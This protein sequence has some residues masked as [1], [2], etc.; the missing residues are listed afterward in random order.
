MAKAPKKGKV[1]AMM[2]VVMKKKGNGKGGSCG[3]NEDDEYK[4]GGMVRGAGCAAKGHGR[5]KMY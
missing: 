4:K 1:P 2:I 3:H 5:G